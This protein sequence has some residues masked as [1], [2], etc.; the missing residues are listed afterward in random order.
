MRLKDKVAV[1]SGGARGMGAA[2][3]KLFA[4]EGCNVIIGDILKDE[5][6]KIVSD[7]RSRGGNCTFLELDVRKEKDWENVVAHAIKEYGKI[8]ILVNNAGLTAEGNVENLTLKE[9]NY[10]MDVNLTGVFLGCKHVLP[11]MRLA[12]SGS[13]IN[14]SSQLGFVGNETSNPAY[15]ASKGGVRIFTK[16]VA[17]TYASYNVR[18]N[19]IHPGPVD[20]PMT[21]SAR[22]DKEFLEKLIAKIP[23]GRIGLP[24]EV[25]W[26]V[27]YLASDESSYVT[28]IELLVDGGWVAQ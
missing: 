4:S 7:I 16:N 3:A 25:A 17:V 10:V 21:E 2:E 11:S 14:I 26:A 1:I 28:G 20:T 22:S 23:M 12:K 13:I 27:L 8:D 24:E 5:S 15:Q 19:S 9:W 18:C 6:L